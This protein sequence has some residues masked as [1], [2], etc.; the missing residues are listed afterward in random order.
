[1]ATAYVF[2]M[3][4]GRSGTAYLTELLGRNLPDAQSHHE[5]LGW[6]RFGVDTP[7]LSHFTLFNSE[8][9]VEKVQAFWRQ[10]LHRVAATPNHFYVE[11]SHLLMKAGLVENLAHLTKDGVVHLIALERDPFATICSFQNRLDFLRPENLWCWYLD[12]KYPKNLFN[13][14]AQ[15]DLNGLCLWY[16]A[17]IRARAAYYARLSANIPNV[18]VHH[19]NFDEILKPIGVARLLSALGVDKAA[20]AVVLPPPQ[21]RNTMKV[22]TPE[23]EEKLKRFIG[24]V[25]FDGDSIAEAAIARG[26]RF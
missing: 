25:H 1:M 13:P 5:M 26:H 22:L 24:S 10:K 9:N 19:F 4:T 3:T 6:D 7:D 15:F 2:T 23:Q 14:A 21:N 17:E 18:R 8:G 11:T 12:P 20:D 16:I